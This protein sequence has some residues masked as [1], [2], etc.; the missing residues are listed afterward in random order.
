MIQILILEKLIGIEPKEAK[1]RSRAENTAL[2][3]RYI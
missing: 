1:M 2:F 3:T